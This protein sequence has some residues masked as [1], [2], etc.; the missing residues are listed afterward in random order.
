MS[1]DEEH[2]DEHYPCQQA[3]EAMK[4]DRDR[5]QE[6]ARRYASNADH[7]QARIAALEADLARTQE[8]CRRVTTDAEKLAA[9][10]AAL[11][12]DISDLRH[13]LSRVR[14]VMYPAT[15]PRDAN[16]VYA[17]A[18][19]VVD[20]VLRKTRPTTSETSGEPILKL[21]C[22]M[23]CGRTFASPEGRN[24]HEEL[25]ALPAEGSAENLCEDCPPLGYPT[26]KTRCTFCPRLTSAAE[27]V[28]SA[29][30]TETK[31]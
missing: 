27:H 17:N 20:D 23:G 11:E 2:L 10:V 21:E 31:L 3:Y 19:S 7:W 25:C 29:S 14:D 22:G 9:K 26:N 1:F 13:V 18:V 12:A 6:D 30:K 28:T 24:H 5:W 15:F 8:V 4:A 16:P